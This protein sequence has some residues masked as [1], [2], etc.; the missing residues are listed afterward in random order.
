MPQDL[1]I[2]IEH[3]PRDEAMKAA[4]FLCDVVGRAHARQMNTSMK[5]N[6]LE[7]LKTAWHCETECSIVA[8]VKRVV[9]LM[10]SRESEYLGHRRKYALN[11]AAE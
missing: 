7:E 11:G 9:D 6:W 1:P 10:V 5:K 3:L 2:E 8:T 4:W